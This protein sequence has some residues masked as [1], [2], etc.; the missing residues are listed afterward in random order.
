MGAGYKAILWNKN[1]RRYDQILW[2]GIFIS[3]GLYVGLSFLFYPTITIETAIIR[4]TALIAVILLHI[5]LMI[6]PL[7]RI[8]RMFLPLL[9]NRRHL[10]VSMFL[11]ALIHGVFCI[12]QFHSLGDTNALVSVFTS[13]VNYQSISSFP[14]SSVFLFSSMT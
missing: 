14:F 6:G 3:L 11:I 10:G 5:I 7:S 1:K 9:Y 2:L 12:I 8:H 13:N 4:G